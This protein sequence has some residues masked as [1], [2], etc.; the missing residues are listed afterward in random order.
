MAVFL[1][2]TCRRSSKEISRISWSRGL[3]TKASASTR[4]RKRD[5]VR[6]QYNSNPFDPAPVDAAA[7]AKYPLVNAQDLKRQTTPPKKVK[8]LARDFIDDSL[9]NPNY[10][11]F[12]KQAVILDVDNNFKKNN[13]GSAIVDPI[14]RGLDFASMRNMNDWEKAVAET[15]GAIEGADFEN[16]GMGRQVWHTPTELFKVKG[17]YVA[18]HMKFW[19]DVPLLN[20]S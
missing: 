6:Y 5:E 20:V 12:P 16:S 2:C 3:A 17:D 7:R 14:K 10:G 18:T 1:P 4:S 8:L 15:Y 13:E 11:Y 9:Y 19:S